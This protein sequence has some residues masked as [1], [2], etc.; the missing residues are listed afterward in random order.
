[1]ISPPTSRTWFVLD[2]QD[3]DVEDLVLEDFV[4][5]IVVLVLDLVFDVENLVLNNFARNTR[6]ISLHEPAVA[7][8]AGCFA[9]LASFWKLTRSTVNK[10]NGVSRKPQNT[11]IE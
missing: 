3:L 6:L 2:V 1:M 10:A 11:C 5:D 8:F 7:I 4:F 9:K